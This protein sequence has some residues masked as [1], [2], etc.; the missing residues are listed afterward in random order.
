[1]KRRTLL[2]LG[3][4]LALATG[5]EAA[6]SQDSSAVLRIVVPF[7]AGGIIDA[8]A[9]LLAN[10][11]AGTLNRS[12]IIDNRPGAA[13]LIGTRAVQ[14]ALPDGATLLFQYI[15]LVGLPFTQKGAN[16]D[17]IKDF[18]PIA[19]VAEGPAFLVVHHDVPAKTVAEFI[20]YAKT[21]PGGIESATSGPGG[22]SHMWTM[23][24]DK[25]AGINLIPVPYKGG[26]EQTR[27]VISGEAKVLI[28]NM[29]EA[30]SGQVKAGT[31]RLLAVA[32]EQ[33][34]AL[35]PGLP[36]IHQTL[37]GF[38]V[39]G[40]NGVFAPAGTP[41]A[42][43]DTISA[44]I[45]KAVEQPAFAAKLSAMYVEA[46]YAGPVEF[47]RIMGTTTEFWRKVVTDL[48]ITPQ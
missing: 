11:V 12:V 8:M 16:Y 42:I 4:T 15:G 27:A 13:G 30:L 2:K 6:W 33:P 34:S 17:P 46:K 18:A 7:P 3:S 29:S 37:P 25:R 23:L 1:M 21:I 5:A 45:K 38:V 22:G 32:S 39:E 26:A 24:F 48:E 10:A 31:V 14:L 20:E 35:A 47:A 9:R 43:V 40:W 44:A 28:S 41:P 36:S 19:M